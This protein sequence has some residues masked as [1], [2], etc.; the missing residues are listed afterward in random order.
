[1]SLYYGMFN[2]DEKEL[3]TKHLVRMIKAQDYHANVGVLGGRALYR[4]LA[5]NG[6][7]DVALKTMLNP[8]F[9]SYKFNLD[10]GLTSLAE[11]F[12]HSESR[13]DNKDPLAR[14][15]SLNHHFWGDIAG[16]F[17][18]CLAGI[19][20]KNC[21]TVEVKPCFNSYM[22]NVRASVVLRE[23]RVSVEYKKTDVKVEMK[24]IVPKGIT[25]SIVAPCGYEIVYGGKLKAG[26]N[27]IT[28]CKKS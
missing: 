14:F 13:I 12:I 21:N 19:C 18:S 3:A 2:D 11:M 17:I 4:A 8:T 27:K 28:F 1:M 20:I 15:W 23:G 24:V 7:V 22:N 6:E 16:F 5:E 10:M 26:E 9:P 25:A